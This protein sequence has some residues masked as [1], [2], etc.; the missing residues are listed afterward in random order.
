MI[1]RFSTFPTVSYLNVRVLYIFLTQL[2]L[3]IM[4]F[5]ILCISKNKTVCLF[6]IVAFVQFSLKQ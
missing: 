2:F 4:L 1:D 5:A 6:K 3:I